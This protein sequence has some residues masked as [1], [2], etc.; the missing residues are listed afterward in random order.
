V[1]ERGR[2]G[3]KEEDLLRKR[4]LKEEDL[5]SGRILKEEVH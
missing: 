1:V 4:R 3:P 5:L 2:D